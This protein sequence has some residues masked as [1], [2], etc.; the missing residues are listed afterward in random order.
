MLLESSYAP[1]LKQKVITHNSKFVQTIPDPD[2]QTQTTPELHPW[3]WC[4]VIWLQLTEKAE[5]LNPKFK[6]CFY[7][8][9]SQ[10]S[11]SVSWRVSQGPAPLSSP[12]ATTRRE[13]PEEEGAAPQ[14]PGRAAGLGCSLKH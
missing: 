12:S 6:I 2:A 5:G 4:E 9:L 8:L 1:V 7:F 10:E 3:P 13:S 11:D 14:E